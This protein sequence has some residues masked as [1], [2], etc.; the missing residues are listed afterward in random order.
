MKEVTMTKRFLI[1]LK[2]HHTKTG[3]T[4]YAVAKQSGLNYNTVNK[5][6]S[7]Y[8]ELDR[9]PAHVI[10]LVQFYGLDWH[11]PSVIEIIDVKDEPSGQLKTLLAVPA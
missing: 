3:L 6:V 9:L 8:V 7:T 10:T 5:F 1:K 11:D 4:P 2:D